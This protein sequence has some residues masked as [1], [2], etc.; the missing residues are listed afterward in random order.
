MTKEELALLIN[1]TKSEPTKEHEKLAKENGLVI[2]YGCSDDLCEF[3]GAIRDEGNCYD[4][5]DIYFS[6]DGTIIDADELQ[7]IVEKL[8]EMD[9]NV[10]LFKQINKI[11]AKWCE[12]ERN[13]ET[14]S[15]TYDTKIPCATYEIYEDGELNC[16][17]LVFSVS[18]LI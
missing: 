10:D 15:W 3:R 6:K 9:F 1:E 11:T 16:I 7:E 4:G 5:G 12:E 13:G 18:D 2:V 8:E 14:I 17:G